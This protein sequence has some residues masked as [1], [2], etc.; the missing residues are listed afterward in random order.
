MVTLPRANCPKKRDC[1]ACI[2]DQS[3]SN[4]ATEYELKLP[5]IIIA[6]IET[7]NLKYDTALHDPFKSGT[8]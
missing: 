2:K 5:F 4:F 7:V 1:L 3:N 8:T 6:D